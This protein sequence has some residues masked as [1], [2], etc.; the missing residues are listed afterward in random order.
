MR[1][2]RMKNENRAGHSRLRMFAAGAVLTLLWSLPLAGQETPR[3]QARELL[4]DSV[5]AQ[6]EEMVDAA[7]RD[8]VPED[9]LFIKALE[10]VSKNVPPGRLLP[11]VAVYRD[12]LGNALE[13]LGP[14][15]PMPTLIA[16]G[17]AL[18]RGVD[19]ESI[20][21]MPVEERTPMTLVVLADL[22]ESGVASEDAVSV[23]REAVARRTAEESMLA[24]PG[25][26]RDLIRDGQSARA[27]A[28]AVRQAIRD[29][30]PIR[31]IPRLGTVDRSPGIPVPPGSDPVT[32]DRRGGG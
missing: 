1:I 32:R 6:L 10:G 21:E 28:D 27:A 26:V 7:A 2:R 14:E 11:A 4:P 30:R 20:R 23:V 3:D 13:L 8:G 31:R 16:G 22:V 29:G 24:I 9:A 5:F 19:P 15:V 17:D 25:A 12:L 18:R